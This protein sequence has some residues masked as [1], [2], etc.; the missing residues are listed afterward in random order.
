VL[1][2]LPEGFETWKTVD[3]DETEV[4]EINLAIWTGVVQELLVY[5]LYPAVTFVLYR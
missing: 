2:K 5:A 3:G 1:I 4:G